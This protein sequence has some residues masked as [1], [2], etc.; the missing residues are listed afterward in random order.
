MSRRRAVLAALA[1]T[2]LG[3]GAGQLAGLA[4]DPGTGP[5]DVVAERVVALTPPAVAE[6]ATVGAGLGSRTTVVAGVLV[7]LALVAALAGAVSGRSERPG[8]WL[9]AGTGV[10][11]VLGAL[12]APGAGQLDPLPS[13]VALLVAVTMFRRLHRLARRIPAPTA[14]GTLPDGRPMRESLTRRRFLRSSAL[15]GAGGI[16]AGTGAAWGAPR[17]PSGRIGEA[18]TALTARLD[19]LAGEGRIAR[20]ATVPAGAG[21]PGGTAFTTP[22]ADFYRIDTALR[23]PAV[24]PDGWRLRV[25]GMVEREL[26]LTLDD[27]LRRPLVERWV[28]LACVSNEVGGD[29]VSTTRFTGI[30]LA[31]LLAAAG[32][33]PAADQVLSTSADGWTAGSPSQIVL[34]PARGALLAVGMDGAALPV[35]HGFP[36]RLV[37]PGLYGYVSATKWVTGIELTTFAQ[38]QDY[39]RV[40]GWAPPGPMETASRIDAPGPYARVPAGPVTVTGTAFAVP[41]G[42]SRVEVGVDGDDGNVV[43]TDAELAP[44]PAGGVTWRMWRCV[45]DLPPGG[46][47]LWCRATDGD[48]A[49]QTGQ[50]RSP[51]PGAATG[52]DSRSVTVVG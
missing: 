40:R 35:E 11:A 23:L 31:P 12:T 30:E 21:F 22:V 18:R 14:Q 17:L 32:P 49:V 44:V 25:H 42:I 4:L 13:A 39:W 5:V 33:D 10:L 28:T 38:R 47:T 15:A 6:L 29:L 52:W 16:V 2:A 48:G 1:A 26:E 9:L 20:A 45:L 37:V 8:M 7:V 36:A 3:A 46:Y 41:R 19:A 27:V 51:L 24:D 34:D 50:V 43:W